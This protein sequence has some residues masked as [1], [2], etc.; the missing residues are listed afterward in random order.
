MT[1]MEQE[2]LANDARAKAAKQR[3]NQAVA[4]RNAIRAQT[5]SAMTKPK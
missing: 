5:E 4:A 2:A 3:L 1:D